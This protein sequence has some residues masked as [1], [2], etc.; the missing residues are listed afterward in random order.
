MKNRIRRMIAMLLVFCIFSSMCGT[1]SATEVRTESNEVAAG[2]IKSG[3]AFQMLADR[4]NTMAS[5][6]GESL[7][8]A[9]VKE[10]NDFA[11][12]TYYLVEYAPTG[13]MICH[14][15]YGNIIEYSTSAPSPYANYDGELYYGGPTYFYQATADGLAH[16]YM[17]EIIST[18]D[19]ETMAIFEAASE[20]M[21]ASQAECIEYA[22][23]SKSESL[24]EISLALSSLTSTQQR[25]MTPTGTITYVGSYSAGLKMKN[26]T[27]EEQMGYYV[28]PGSNGVCGYIAAGLMLYW[29]DEC[30]GIDTYINDF[31]YIRSDHNGFL[32][33]SLSRELR[34]FGSQDGTDAGGYVSQ[35]LAEILR[36]YADQNS[37]SISVSSA[38]TGTS[39]E[40]RTSLINSNKPILVTGYLTYDGTDYDNHV[41]LAYGYTSD[42]DEVIVHYGHEDYSQVVLTYMY[43][44]SY[45]KLHG[46]G[47]LAVNINDISSTNW[48][49]LAAMYCARYGIMSTDNGSFDP[50]IKMNRGEFVKSLYILAG[51]PKPPVYNYLSQFDDAPDKRSSELYFNAMNWAVSEGILTGVN[52]NTLGLYRILTREQA[53]TFLYRYSNTLGCGFP[54]GAGG[55]AA[56]TFGDYSS[57]SNFARTAMDWATRRYLIEG[58]SGNLYPLRELTRAET[59]K[60]IYNLSNKASR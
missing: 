20:E 49:Y 59:A 2:T 33:S 18:A 9:E 21:N 54:G 41:V 53:A 11:G 57:V 3:S 36:T 16:T 48:A 50:T 17:E 31:S 52:E 46:Y 8:V 56:N 45:L 28:P 58:S 10:L 1:A 12:N 24:D 40:V 22:V 43:I 29:I 6:T 42:V 55:P 14:A 5:R 26:L 39:A 60:L 23:T 4:V 15:E 27:T 32:D 44:G 13:Y 19:Q 34:S 25:G 7:T 38:F 30:A 47:I 37:L 35:S 51:K